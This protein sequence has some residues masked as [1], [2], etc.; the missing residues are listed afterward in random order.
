MKTA[1]KMFVYRDKRRILVYQPI[2]ESH[3]AAEL[4]RPGFIHVAVVSC[5][6]FDEGRATSYIIDKLRLTVLSKLLFE[7]CSV[8]KGALFLFS[9]SFLWMI[10]LREV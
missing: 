7:D 6:H 10:F 3:I 2:M 9:L 1:G 8:S 4:H 5:R